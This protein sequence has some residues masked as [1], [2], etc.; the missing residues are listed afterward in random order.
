MRRLVF[1]SSASVLSFW[2]GVACN[3]KSPTEV[4][5]P[6]ATEVPVP[7]PQVAEG[8]VWYSCT[9]QSSTGYLINCTFRCVEDDEVFHWT[10]EGEGVCTGGSEP[11]LD[12]PDDPGENLPGAGGTLPPPAPGEVSFNIECD[13]IVERRRAASCQVTASDSD[14]AAVSPTQFTV[15]RWKAILMDE[16]VYETTDSKVWAGIAVEGSDEVSAEVSVG[17][18]ARGWVGPAGSGSFQVEP[19]DWSWSVSDWSHGRGTGTAPADWDNEPDWDVADQRG[20]SLCAWTDPGCP[21]ALNPFLYPDYRV[22]DGYGVTS[23]PSGPNKGLFYVPSQ[24]VGIQTRSWI[25]DGYTPVWPKRT[26][27]AGSQADE[28]RQALGLGPS[29]PAEVNFFTFN[30][31]CKGVDMYGFLR[32]VKDHEEDHHVLAIAAAHLDGYNAPMKL[33]PLVFS[34]EEE[35]REEIESALE[36]VDQNLK[37]AANAFQPTGNW[38]GRVWFWD[39]SLQAYKRSG[40]WGF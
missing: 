10:E 34:S 19:Q 12:G 16:T 37:S 31:V 30:A 36:L 1:L 3:H 39:S 14:G 13:P 8:N 9:I 32:G 24:S 28:C 18:G 35:L 2:V 11:E 6:E 22:G 26:L 20:A 7:P 29:D 23:V 33:E 17:G 40:L 5:V 38:S 21:V 4:D 15:H 27:P 25:N